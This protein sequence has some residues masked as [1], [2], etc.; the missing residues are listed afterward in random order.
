MATQARCHMFEKCFEDSN[1][2]PVPACIAECAH[3]G[4]SCE[5]LGKCD[6]SQCDEDTVDFI[7]AFIQ[8]GCPW[9][10]NDGGGGGS[11]SG[12]TGGGGG[13]GPPAVMDTCM[14]DTCGKALA[15]CTADQDCQL[16]IMMGGMPPIDTA[17]GLALATCACSG[18]VYS[19]PPMMAAESCPGLVDDWKHAHFTPFDNEPTP[20]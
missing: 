19:I 8:M 1:D 10:I 5:V 14:F 15:E 17:I 9:D 12:A 2:G 20:P 6:T 16:A 7:A 3:E 4:M 18:C 11:G 13:D